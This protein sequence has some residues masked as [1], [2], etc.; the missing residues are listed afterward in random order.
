MDIEKIKNVASKISGTDATKLN[1]TDD[2]CL[3]FNGKNLRLTPWRYDRRLLAVRAL[4]VEENRLRGICSYKSVVVHKASEDIKK[5]LLAELDTCQW[6]LDDSIV[7]VYAIGNP[8]KTLSVMMRTEGDIL[9]SIEIATTLSEDTAPITR[10]EIVGLEGMISDRSINEQVP[11][12]AIYV[13]EDGKKSPTTYTDM[14]SLMLGCTPYEVSVIDN[15][16][17]LLD[18]REENGVENALE[19][20]RYLCDCVMKSIE[21]GSVIMIKE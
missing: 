13:F 7:S 5:L 17:Y 11:F 18:S 2:L 21:T 19:D 12:E 8:D 10:H 15:I 6:L 20:I 4:S 16:L 9:C 3:S 14:D 1:M